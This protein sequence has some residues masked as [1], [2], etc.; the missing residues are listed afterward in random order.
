VGFE[1]HERSW[2]ELIFTEEEAEKQ[3][4]ELVKAYKKENPGADE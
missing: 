3:A 2:P 4:E 1:R